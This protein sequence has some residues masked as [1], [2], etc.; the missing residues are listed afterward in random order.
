MAT[1]AERVH[2]STIG[3]GQTHWTALLE[4]LN[5]LSPWLVVIAYTLTHGTALA[6]A[7]LVTVYMAEALSGMIGV[8][9][10]FTVGVGLI[11]AT[12]ALVSAWFTRV[13]DAHADR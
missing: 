6:G 12:P 5:E 7:A 3:T 10:F 13:L 4:H 11:A 2:E 9:V 8:A 1:T